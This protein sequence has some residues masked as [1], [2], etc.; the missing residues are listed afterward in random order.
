MYILYILYIIIY[1]IYII[2]YILHIYIYVYISILLLGNT[3]FGCFPFTMWGC[4]FLP[5]C[6]P[7]DDDAV[8]FSW[9]SPAPVSCASVQ[10]SS[11]RHPARNGW[12]LG[13]KVG[14]QS[15]PAI[16]QVALTLHRL[17]IY[18]YIY[19]FKLLIILKPTLACL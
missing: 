2:L 16:F 8:I 12:R 4:V 11:R 10:C 17:W 1:I 7:W 5:W 6:V 19:M 9:P 15:G 18:I 14:T 13:P 3:Y